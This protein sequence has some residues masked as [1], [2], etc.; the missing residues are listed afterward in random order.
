MVLLIGPGIRRGHEIQGGS[1]LDVAPTIL[2]LA[3][4]SVGREMEGKVWLQ[5]FVK[6]PEVK[7][8]SYPPRKR[9][10][11]GKA[12]DLDKKRIDDLKSLGYL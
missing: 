7:F 10:A 12:E 4:L 5:A 11:G 2:T 3:G 1:V 8:R 9:G 6:P